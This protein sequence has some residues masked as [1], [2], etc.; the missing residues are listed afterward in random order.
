MAATAP[1]YA[2]PTALPAT[3]APT[4]LPSAAPAVP[5]PPP[6]S[7]ATPAPTG[8]V[9]PEGPIFYNMVED[10][11]N[12]YDVD[13]SATGYYYFQK[14]TNGSAK[15]KYELRYGRSLWNKNA[16]IRIRIPYW[17]QY[18]NS[19]SPYSGL[20]NIEIA[21]SYNVA[22]RMFDHSMEFRV[23]F[24]TTT[25]H[26]VSNDTQIKGFYTTKWKWPGG[27]AIY[28]NEY[29]QSVIV[30]PG[31]SWTSYYEGKLDIPNYKITPGITV[32]AI[33]NYRVLFD[34]NGTFKPAV[35]GTVFGNFN[36]VAVSLTDTWGYGPNAL[37][38]YKPEINVTAKF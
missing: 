22:S 38:K 3:P 11:D 21:Y 32:A 25:N 29:D 19:G 36:D 12:N 15:A 2:Q 27:A 18:P 28:V 20:G 1:C 5:P 10:I 7:G 8:T 23:A 24:P 26:V 9:S 34:T 35:G 6:P 30:P 17:T 16:V 31:A 37:W 14:N 33:Y 4:P 13:R